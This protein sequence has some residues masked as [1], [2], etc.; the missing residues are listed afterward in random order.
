MTIETKK[1]EFARLMSELRTEWFVFD[2]NPQDPKNINQINTLCNLIVNL[3]LTQDQ[4]N[5]S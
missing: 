5:D 2:M 1:K 4:V 3:G